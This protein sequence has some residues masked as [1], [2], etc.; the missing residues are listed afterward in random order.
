MEDERGATS[1]GTTATHAHWI[2]GSP[3]AC[4]AAT[5]ACRTGPPRWR[6]GA[7]AASPAAV[8][9]GDA[10]RVHRPGVDRTDARSDHSARICDPWIDG[11]GTSRR[12]V[13]RDGGHGHEQQRGAGDNERAEHLRSCAPSSSTF[14]TTVILCGPPRLPSLP[15]YLESCTCALATATV[16]GGRAR[17]SGPAGPEGQVPAGEPA[18]GT[19]RTMNRCGAGPT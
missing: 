2:L 10:L 19:A 13:A 1:P 3:Y 17:H 15:A 14:A 12:E 5:A 7:E 8:R 9:G 6:G 18:A 4:R 11:G 16:R